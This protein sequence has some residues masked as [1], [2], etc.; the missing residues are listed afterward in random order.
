MIIV[1]IFSLNY[2]ILPGKYTRPAILDRGAM[3]FIMWTSLVWASFASCW[4]NCN[5]K[6]S[7]PGAC[8][9]PGKHTRTNEDEL[10]DK[11]V[12]DDYDKIVV[13]Y[14]TK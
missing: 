6:I 11:I 7:E 3:K 2:D 5:M 14:E 12:D 9:A 4:R 8:E 10:D 1:D 13:V